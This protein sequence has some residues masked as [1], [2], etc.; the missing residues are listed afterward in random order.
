MDCILNQL[1]VFY[2]TIQHLMM[3]FSVRKQEGLYQ[4]SPCFPSWKSTKNMT[5]SGSLFSSVC[6]CTRKKTE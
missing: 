3:D 4:S 5:I 2:F 6:N 1:N